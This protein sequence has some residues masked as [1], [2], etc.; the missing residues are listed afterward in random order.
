MDRNAIISSLESSNVELRN[1]HIAIQ[2]EN[3]EGRQFDFVSHPRLSYAVDRLR[4]TIGKIDR[5]VYQE[6]RKG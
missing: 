6:K 2:N 3:G 1:L 4:T 5:I